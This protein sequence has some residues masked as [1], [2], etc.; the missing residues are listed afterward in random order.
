MKG[1]NDPERQHNAERQD[2]SS[3][4]GN[5]PCCHGE[6]DGCLNHNPQ[7]SLTFYDKTLSLGDKAAKSNSKAPAAGIDLFLPEQVWSQVPRT[8]TYLDAL[9]RIHPSVPYSLSFYHVNAAIRSYTQQAGNSVSS[10]GARLTALT[11]RGTHGSRPT[12]HWTATPQ[13]VSTSSGPTFLLQY[14]LSFS[15][16][17]I[18][19]RTAS[20]AWSAGYKKN[21]FV[22]PGYRSFALCHHMRRI[23]RSHWSSITQKQGLRAGVAFSLKNILKQEFQAEWRSELGIQPVNMCCGMCYTDSSMSFF[24]HERSVWVNIT[25]DKDLGSGDWPCLKWDMALRGTPTQRDKAD[26]MRMRRDFTASPSHLG[27]PSK[28]S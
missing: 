18:V 5:L 17:D 11:C 1:A 12:I 13:I 23:F 14:S 16:N 4:Q 3:W 7:K 6:R 22:S 20:G 25:A 2:D 21:W 24:L 9:P 28:P 19:E 8:P 10:S 26:F 15:I 27:G